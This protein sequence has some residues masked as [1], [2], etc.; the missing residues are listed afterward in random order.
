[1]GKIKVLPEEVVAK[2]AAGEVIER[3]GSVVK[4]L[5]ENSLDAGATMISILLRNGG[6]SL[7][8]VVDNGE[9]MDREDTANALFR[10]ATSKIGSLKDMS[11]I[12][13]LGFRGEALPSI[14]AVSRFTIITKDA[15]IHLGTEIRG[16]A[17]RIEEVKDSERPIG[18]TVEVRDLFFNLPVRR[19][20]LKSERIEYGEIIDMVNRLSIAHPQTAFRLYRDGVLAFDYPSC[21]DLK[22]RTS[23][24]C[25]R[26]WR[27]AL[28]P[29]TIEQEEW[30]IN[31]FIGKPEIT[32]N[33]RSG[34]F[35]FV[36]QRPV[37]ILSFTF[38]LQH[39]FDGTLPQGRFPI[40]VL[41][42][43]INPVN[44][45][46]NIHPHKREVRIFN[47]GAIQSIMVKGIRE[48]LRVKGSPPLINLSGTKEKVVSVN[49]PAQ[50]PLA[51]GTFYGRGEEMVPPIPTVYHLPRQETVS[52]I[53]EDR[54]ASFRR[55][56][57]QNEVTPPSALEK[58]RWG[59]IYGQLKSSYILIEVEDGLMVIDQHAA[60]ERIVYEEILHSLS[61]GSSPSQTLLVPLL[62]HLDGRESAVLEEYLPILSKMGFG[63]NE[64]GNNSFSIDARPSFLKAEEVFETLRDFIQ[65][66]SMGRSRG[67]LVETFDEAA[68]IIAC[69]S[70]SIKAKEELTFVEI[71]ELIQRLIRANQP[72]TCPH[73]RP[74]VIKLTT[75]EL[76]AKF[77]R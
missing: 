71:K 60:H 35:F 9:G 31:G 20:F 30:Q 8:R 62:L 72:F 34:Q 77:L 3:P 75:R 32:R 74:T 39:S 1:M 19:K 36:N 64:L 28:I 18:T 7:I 15:S 44:V 40:A 33:S 67:P 55:L 51:Q 13:S 25:P 14:A 61:K 10:Y 38:A 63:I 41:F 46:V 73:G 56:N 69:K 17:G 23:Q 49:I 37:K 21:S 4:E 2:I 6:K 22:D 66:V 48:A 42:L 12:K 11:G 50:R 5:V 43:H 54:P 65:D 59:R 70:R 53:A 24:V 26:E 52:T 58:L 16:E 45:D 27:E 47:E 68:R 76:E 29:L 57:D